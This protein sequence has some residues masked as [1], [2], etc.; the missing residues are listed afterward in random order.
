MITAAALRCKL[1]V[2]SVKHLVDSHGD[3]TA[4]EIELNA[5][6]G[7]AGTENA[8]WSK[9]TPSASFKMHISNP[10]AFG[11]LKV[12]GEYYVDITPV[13]AADA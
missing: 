10:N 1:R 13:P 2:N 7:D 6:Y 11:V 4:E 9:Y 12:G 8:Q 5:V 3:T